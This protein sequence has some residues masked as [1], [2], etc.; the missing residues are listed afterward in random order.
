MGQTGSSESPQSYEQLSDTRNPWA[1]APDPEDISDG[2]GVESDKELENAAAAMKQAN[3]FRPFELITHLNKAIKDER[4]AYLIDVVSEFFAVFSGAAPLDT[5]EYINES[6]ASCVSAAK[7]YQFVTIRE[8]VV[9]VEPSDNYLYF[10]FI[11]YAAH[12]QGVTLRV[13]GTPT[14]AMELCLSTELALRE[15]EHSLVLVDLLRARNRGYMRYPKDPK[16]AMEDTTKQLTQ[17]DKHQRKDATT[18]NPY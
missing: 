9:R 11:S 3:I 2:R 6:I 1:A 4:H 15:G 10:I 8:G 14:R 5:T 16:G 17:R 18:G 7:S 13:E 12:K